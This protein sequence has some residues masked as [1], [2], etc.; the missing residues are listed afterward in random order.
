MNE[1]LKFN[2]PINSAEERQNHYDSIEEFFR[3]FYLQDIRVML[4][5]WLKA[6]MSSECSAYNTGYERSNLLFVYEK[7][8]SDSF[9]EAANGINQRRKRRRK[10]IYS[11][12]TSSST[13]FLKIKT[14]FWF[15]SCLSIKVI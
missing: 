6:A 9:L 14:R 5:E 1:S 3:C 13:I 11:S 7:L 10:R 2:P 8:D 12:L 15:L 4:W